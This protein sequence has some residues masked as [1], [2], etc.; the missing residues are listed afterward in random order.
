[1]NNLPIKFRIKDNQHYISNLNNRNIRHGKGY[2]TLTNYY[3]MAIN[4]SLNRINRQEL[5]VM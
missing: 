3:H 4:D 1:M 5:I 2:K